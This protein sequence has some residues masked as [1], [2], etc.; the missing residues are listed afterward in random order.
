VDISL[1]PELEK[2]VKAKIAS[3]LYDNASE[4]ISEALQ[5]LLLRDREDDWL[6]REAAIGFAQLD[7]GQAVSI[8]SRKAFIAAVRSLS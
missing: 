4:V 2:A 1:T 5:M 7:A 8:E 6:L 3:G